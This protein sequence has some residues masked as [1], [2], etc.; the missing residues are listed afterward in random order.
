MRTRKCQSA[1]ASEIID[2]FCEE[3][4]HEPAT[5]VPE[6]FRRSAMLHDST[7]NDWDWTGCARMLGKRIVAI[8]GMSVVVILLALS[9]TQTTRAEG[10]ERYFFKD[11]MTQQSLKDFC[12]R[13]GCCVDID[14]DLMVIW[15]KKTDQKELQPFSRWLY[16]APKYGFSD[17]E[18]STGDFCKRCGCCAP[19]GQFDWPRFLETPETMNLDAVESEMYFILDVNPSGDY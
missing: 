1:S 6:I 17:D 14:P 2:R 5:P 11:M 7:A 9:A 19:T 4:D 16:A 10:T 15:T 13:C 3:C 8:S 12:K 18:R